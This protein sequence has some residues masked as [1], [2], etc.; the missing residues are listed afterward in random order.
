M[1]TTERE[2]LDALQE[3]AERLGKSPTKAEYEELG[4]RPASATIIRVVG[5][6]N[7]AKERTLRRPTLALSKSLVEHGTDP[8]ASRPT[9]RVGERPQARAWLPSVWGDRPGSS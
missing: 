1:R 4:L 6:W 5:G 3:A 8:K 7:E 9:P 2:C